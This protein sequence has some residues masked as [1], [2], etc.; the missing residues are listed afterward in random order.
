M[1]LEDEIDIARG[2]VILSPNEAPGPAD[3]FAAHLLWMTDDPMLPGR[4]YLLK[5][6]CTTVNATITEIK[7]AVNVNSLEH[8]AAK[9]LQLNEVGLCNFH[10]DRALPFEPYGQNPALGSFILI[11][12]N[13]NA[14]IAAGMI[15]HPLYRASNLVWQQMTVDKATRAAMKSQKP[16]V[17]WLT[18]L[19]GAG[20]STI[21]N[22]LEQKLLAMQ[23]HSYILD[24]D[25]VRH[26]LNQDL[27]FTDADRVENIRRVS[28]TAKLFVDAGL[29]VLVSFISPFRSERQA[30]RDLLEPGEFFEVHIA[31]SLEDC[32]Q[33]DPKGLYKKARAGK[34]ANF[35]GIDSPYEVPENPEIRIDTSQMTP[36]KAADFILD[37]LK[38]AGVLS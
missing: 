8:Q 16:A 9:V 26:G 11:D 4:Q 1:V 36:E 22:I 29:I 37:H 32:E 18:G 13:S 5:Q 21:A 33:R 28:E 24:G 3:Q 12:R 27:G 15:T 30:A 34:I 6:G 19:S 31:T 20:K 35:T 38:K 2:D 7:H 17:L 10:L 14:T 25:N 23:R